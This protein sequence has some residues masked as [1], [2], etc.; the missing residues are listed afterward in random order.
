MPRPYSCARGVAPSAL[1]SLLAATDAA[2]LAVAVADLTNGLLYLAGS[3]PAD[4]APAWEDAVRATAQATGGYALAFGR[5][6]YP[7]RGML[8]APEARRMLAELKRRWDPAGILNTG[9][10]L[11]HTNEINALKQQRAEKT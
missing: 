8:M 6:V 10:F 11:G 1:P 7:P 3:E 4:V 9:V 5:G 2:A